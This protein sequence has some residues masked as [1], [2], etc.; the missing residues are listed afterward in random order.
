[1]HD[2][3]PA[4]DSDLP[5]PLAAQLTAYALDQLEGEERAAVE[6]LLGG[7]DA[8]AAR[9]HVAAMRSMA[10]ALTASRDDDTRRS[11]DLRRA[12]LAAAATAS[13]GA[14]PVA[15]RPVDAGFRLPRGVLAA[16]SLAAAVAVAAVTWRSTDRSPPARDVALVDGSRMPVTADTP[17]PAA[18]AAPRSHADGEAAAIAGAAAAP[19]E[20]PKPPLADR[21]AAATTEAAAK[22]IVMDEALVN[23]EDR[24]AAKEA[25]ATALA[26]AAPR[27]Q[28]RGDAGPAP[29]GRGA[30]PGV[31]GGLGGLASDIAPAGPAPWG[32]R[33]LPTMESDQLAVVD[34]RRT[35]LEQK[36]AERLP[37]E[38]FEERQGR[39]APLDLGRDTL[40]RERFNRFT[41]NPPAAVRTE[42]LSTFSID[43]DTASYALIRR[44]L[45][46]GQMPPRDAVRIEEL[47]NFFRY[48]LPQPDGDMPFSVTVEAAGCPWN[49]RTR[50]VRVALQGRH[51]ERAARPAGNLVFLIDV[52]GS[53]D[54]PDKLPL[55]KQ[56]L[57][58]L[59]EEL[60]ENDRVAIVTYAGEAGL[61]LP[62]VSGDQ[63]ARIR[64][65]IDTLKPGGS[66]HGSAG[67]EMAYDQAAERFIEGGVN[68][69]ILA[70][71][72]DLNVGVTSDEALVDLVR[73]KAAG[74]TF[75]TVLG[76]GRGNLQDEKLEALAD[77]GNGMYA[78]IDGA[79]EARRVLVE[80]LGG[81]LVTIAKDVKIQVEFNPA[82]VA[83]YR[84]IGYE[85]RALAAEDFRDDRKDAGEIGAG[86][87]VTALYEIELVDGG[88]AADR[89]A[90]PLKYRPTTPAEPATVLDEA[91]SRELLTVKLRWKRP[92]GET[93]TLT[94]VPLADAGA[95]FSSASTDLRFAAAVAAFGMILRDSRHA[96]TATLGMV[97]EIAGDSLGSDE[98]GLR[99]E[100]LD[101][102]RRAGEIGTTR[103]RR[104]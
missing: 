32:G 86:H 70:T 6:R 17:F 16:G 82:R 87:S 94:E 48:D 18:A 9:E 97:S 85:N 4:H 2:A 59:V 104:D 5:E 80:Q 96:G 10:A 39:V 68:R 75:L 35:G 89:G 67:I 102:V 88:A 22:A 72:G 100:F 71:D 56:A 15:S 45:S 27:R 28:P 50:L 47:V 103:T 73:R 44:F 19:V 23:A 37:A 66:T 83:S 55:V 81:S 77:K 20:T 76:F 31:A 49:E 26:D 74:G 79:R 13:R 57:G 92:D 60:G 11:P 29:G 30:V 101:L 25:P 8:E 21:E 65:A 99:A 36:A 62:P 61:V 53:M 38:R 3:L 78:Y 42:P 69:V 33:A 51:V 7:A 54:E 12:V 14:I 46:S 95:A 52:S 43:V 63:K 41:E 24:P 34:A 64:Q 98:G 1:M 90:E 91:T 93:S 84:L 40:N 58:M